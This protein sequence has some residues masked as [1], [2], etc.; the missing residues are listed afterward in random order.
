MNNLF[1]DSMVMQFSMITLLV[2]SAAYFALTTLTVGTATPSG[3]FIPM[4]L[5]GASFGRALGVLVR[6]VLQRESSSDFPCLCSSLFP[7]RHFP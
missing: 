3:A 5:V 6:E 7:L 4:V 1:A 2:Y